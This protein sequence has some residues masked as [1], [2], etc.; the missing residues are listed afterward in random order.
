MIGDSAPSSPQTVL[1]SGRGLSAP[2]VSLAP[3]ALTF[4]SQTLGTA[5]PTQSISLSNTGGGPLVL[6]SVDIGGPGAADFSQTNDCPAS[7]NAGASCSVAVTFTPS[8]EGLRSAALTLNDN[9]DDSPQAVSLFGAGVAAGTYF[10]DDFESG[11]LA[12]WN[13]LTSADSTVSLDST[14]A[15]SGTTSVRVTNRSGD[16]ASRLYADLA[17][18][19]HAQTYTH[20]C[21]NIRRGTRKGSKSRTGARSPTSTRWESA[22]G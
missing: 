10:A 14:V 12:Q 19:G 22:A 21:F 16:Q 5:S 7:L 3:S 13:V 1:L 18:G 4:S 6:G 8:A 20:F 2:V 9:A 11:S 15:H 17:G